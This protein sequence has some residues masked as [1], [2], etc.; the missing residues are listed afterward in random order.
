[1]TFFDCVVVGAW[2]FAIGWSC[3]AV[4]IQNQNEKRKSPRAA[5]KPERSTDCDAVRLPLAADAASGD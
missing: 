3:G 4:Y 2:A 5:G 1:M